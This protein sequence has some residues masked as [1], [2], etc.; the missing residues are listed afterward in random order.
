MAF[1]SER[2][3]V[4]REEVHRVVKLMLDNDEVGDIRCEEQ[5]DGT[6]RV[7]PFPSTR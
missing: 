2:Y 3:D 6:Y 1:P 5:P 7:K 4:P